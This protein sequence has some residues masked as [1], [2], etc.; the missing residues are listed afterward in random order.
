[1][2]K[3]KLME[4]LKVAA[5]DYNGGMGA[6]AAVAKAAEAA[7]F[8]EYQTDRLVEMFNTLAAINQEKD[9][10]DPTGA[11]ELASK[12]AVAKILLDGSMR[13]AA[14]APSTGDPFRYSFYSGD[15]L[16]TNRSIEARESGMA[17]M[18]KA[19]SAECQVK[20]ELDVSQRSLYKVICE[21]ID[22][23]KS[24]SDA[25]DEA[26]RVIKLEVERSAVKVA[27]AI[28][29]PFAPAEV[30]DMF[31]AA[32]KSEKAVGLIGEYS[33]KVAESTGGKYSGME[34]FDASPVED[35]LETAAEIETYIGQIPE[36]EK[37]RDLYM[38]KASE[39]EATMKEILGLAKK[40]QKE[41][42]ADFFNP[43]SVVK[44][45]S[46]DGSEPS[47]GSG[48]EKPSLSVKIAEL[49]RKSGIKSEEVE[50]LA[51]ELEK[52]A[53]TPG[54]MTMLPINTGDALSAFKGKDSVSDEALRLQNV[55]RGLLLSDAIANDPILRDADPRMISQIYKSIVK[56]A[57]RI[58]L[59]PALVISVLRTAANSVALSPADA[60]VLTDVDKGI[61]LS[62][63]ERLTNL[64][65]SIKDSNRA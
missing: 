1:M 15:P 16:R 65:S 52:D 28:E 25:A 26:A 32:C 23:L 62:N 60:K 53:A 6:N 34:V 4:A 54:I 58:S 9:A 43:A 40:A 56:S 2:I 38:S 24:A 61:A 49:I 37:K 14:S 22:L 51:Q 31:K 17:S 5:A 63:I 45:A 27:K 3:E 50:K 48:N 19:A 21:K 20:P 10:S 57:P 44:K 64:D 29:S 18:T 59:D 30:A 47:D 8:N 11:C 7:D 42:I 46:E 13:K 12:G 36:Y 41:S 33:T 39:A 55:E 35:L